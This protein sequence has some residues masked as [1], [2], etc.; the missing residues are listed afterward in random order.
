MGIPYVLLKLRHIQAHYTDAA[1]SNMLCISYKPVRL[2]LS[3]VL[4]RGY[5]GPVQTRLLA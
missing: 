3:S 5:V 4:S 2:D 1:V